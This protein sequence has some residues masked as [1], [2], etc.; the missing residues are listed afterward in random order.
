MVCLNDI[1]IVILSACLFFAFV[2]MWSFQLLCGWDWFQ[3]D[4]LFLWSVEI[5]QSINVCPASVLCATA[6]SQ[7]LFK[8][9]MFFPRVSLTCWQKQEN[10]LDFTVKRDGHVSCLGG[11]WQLFVSILPCYIPLRTVRACTD[12]LIDISVFWLILWGGAV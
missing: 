12:W 10:L 9:A 5:G 2:W 1:V 3:Q 8:S 11:H 6:V 7:E 4:C